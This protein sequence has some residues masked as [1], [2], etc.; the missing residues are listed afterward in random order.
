MKLYMESHPIKTLQFH[1]L[2]DI[3]DCYEFSMANKLAVS[4]KTTE[5][6]QWAS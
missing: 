3:K 1:L 4:Q 6:L 2:G 5:S